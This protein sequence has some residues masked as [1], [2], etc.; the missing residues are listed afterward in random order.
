[1]TLAGFAA[2]TYYR[3]TEPLRRDSACLYPGDGS[4]LPPVNSLSRQLLPISAEND[5][6]TSSDFESRHD[7]LS[8]RENSDGTFVAAAPT[9]PRIDQSKVAR[10]SL[11]RS[12]DNINSRGEVDRSDELNGSAPASL[13]M[14][15]RANSILVESS[16]AFG[17]A[18]AVR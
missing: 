11:D 12:N 5:Q 15:S 1:M 13:P 18:L 16:V 3:T 8:S 9:T 6:S 4:S 17:G 7:E 2:F 14:H 10:P